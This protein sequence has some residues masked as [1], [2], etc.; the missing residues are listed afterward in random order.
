MRLAAGFFALLIFVSCS[1]GGEAQP[2]GTLE[3]T[4]GEVTVEENLVTSFE[5][6]TEDET[7]TIGIDPERDYGFDLFHLEEHASTGDPVIVET[8]TEG[9]DL[10]AV[11]IED[12]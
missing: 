10:V 2:E 5:L 1:S 11:T 7:V 9:D 12:V 3:G 4:V 6:E 8:E